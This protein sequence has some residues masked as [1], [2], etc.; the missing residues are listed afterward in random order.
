MEF[1]PDTIFISYSRADG[2]TFA[3]AFER[4]LKKAGIGS[5]RDLKSM[6]SGDIRP[7]V[8]RA[9]EYPEVARLWSSFLAWSARSFA[10]ASF[11]HALHPAH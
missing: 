11:S 6:G 2:R 10:R 3:E 7:Q 8:L 1:S 5:W 4:Q 9:I